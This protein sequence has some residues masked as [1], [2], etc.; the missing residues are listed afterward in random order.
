MLAA[1]VVGPPAT[2]TMLGGRC[3][4]RAHTARNLA[5][6]VHSFLFRATNGRFGAQRARRAGARAGDA[7]SQVRQ[8]AACVPLLFVE[9]A[10]DWVVMASSG[11]DPQHPAWFLNLE[12]EPRATVIAEAGRRAVAATVTGGEASASACSGSWPRSTAASRVSRPARVR[13]PGRMDL[14]AV[15]SV[16]GDEF[17]DQR[18]ELG[19]LGAQAGQV[20]DDAFLRAAGEHDDGL[21]VGRGVLL[22][23]RHVGRHV[24]VVA[25][26][27]LDAALLAVLE[28]DEDGLARDDVDAGLGLAV[29]VIAGDH[30]GARR[31][32][33]PSRS[34]ASRCACPRSPRSAACPGVCAVSS[35]SSSW[36][37]WWRRRCQAALPAC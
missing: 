23:V 21:L 16:L 34:C 3:T 6:H 22:A 4:G 10:G 12:A 1:S 18:V 29:V 28:E 35:L 32:S 24:D 11:G 25:G 30:A 33:C 14:R 31:G 2:N 26:A 37:V 36:P 7:R 5:T 19:D 15:F 13:D 27:G 17:G 20:D 9:D 8:G